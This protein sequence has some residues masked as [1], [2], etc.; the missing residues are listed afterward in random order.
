M[1][2]IMPAFFQRLSCFCSHKP[3]LVGFRNSGCEHK[4]SHSREIPDPPGPD[5]EY[6]TIRARSVPD[7][8]LPA[9]L[10]RQILETNRNFLSFLMKNEFWDLFYLEGRFLGHILELYR[11]RRKRLYILQEI[12][13]RWLQMKKC[14]F[15]KNWG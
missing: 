9:L 4:G 3:C 6:T 12:N 14:F 8:C 11:T 1:S 13:P 10:F 2:S 5:T 15:M 7:P